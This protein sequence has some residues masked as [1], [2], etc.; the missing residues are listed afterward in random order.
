M[1][2]GF[3]EIAPPIKLAGGTVEGVSV[4]LLASE[5]GFPN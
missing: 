1:K 4:T 3:K 2:L 5:M